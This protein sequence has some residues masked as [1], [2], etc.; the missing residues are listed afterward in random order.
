[1][2]M[3]SLLLAAAALTLLVGC[4]GNKSKPM[5]DTKPVMSLAALAAT[6]R[7]E[8]TFLSLQKDVAPIA[9]GSLTNMP[10]LRWLDLTGRRLSEIPGEVLAQQ[11]LE[12][13]W[14]GSNAL[15]NLPPEL[16][17]LEKL[18]YL[19]LDHN[20]LESVPK[21]LG[22]LGGIMWLRLNDNKIGKFPEELAGLQA[23][24]SFYAARN[25]LK[26]VPEFLNKCVMLDDVVL[27]GNPGIKSVPDWF[28]RKKLVT[29]SFA[30]CGV[31]N[32]P[33][34]LS[35]W[36]GLKSLSLGGCPIPAEEM[37]RIRKELGDKVA[38][39]F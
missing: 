18:T 1:M 15:T 16:M 28:A 13:L 4:F 38:I 32:L 3:K 34:N 17:K 24:R 12:R 10:A 23:L 5:G 36:T 6:N 27:D 39:T 25:Q 20:R 37:A 8:V 35:R 21:D 31:T 29:V 7:A 19:N 30:G 33:Q 22:A 14:L 2:H 11:G 9:A 26:E